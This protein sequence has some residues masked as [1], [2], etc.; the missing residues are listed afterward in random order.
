[1]LRGVQQPRHP[2]GIATARF[3]AGTIIGR[4]RQQTNF[5]TMG[6]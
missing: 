5:E 2:I 3:L 6:R 1:M 4:L